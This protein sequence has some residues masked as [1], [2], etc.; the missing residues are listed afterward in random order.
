MNTIYIDVP[1]NL[2]TGYQYNWTLSKKA[3]EVLQMQENIDAVVKFVCNNIYKVSDGDVYSLT[4]STPED[5]TLY[6]VKNKFALVDEDK[7][8]RYISTH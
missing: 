2:F 7:V 4:F 6:L 3:E 8:I 5:V 1:S